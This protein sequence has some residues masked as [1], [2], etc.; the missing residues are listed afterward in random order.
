MKI[1][2]L[3]EFSESNSQ[4]FKDSNVIYLARKWS[5]FLSRL[6]FAHSNDV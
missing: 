2:I 3:S 4:H 1:G 6:Y 5:K